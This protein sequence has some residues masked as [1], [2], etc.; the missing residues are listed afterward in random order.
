[1]SIPI[2][3]QVRVLEKQTKEGKDRDGN[4]RTYYNLKVADTQTFDNQIIGVSEEIFKKVEEN[5]DFR[6]IGKCGGLKEKYWYFNEALPV[7][8]KK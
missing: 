8:E 2:F 1:M 3:T 5:K 4:A 7:P 6:F